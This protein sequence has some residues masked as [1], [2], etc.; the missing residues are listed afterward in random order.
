MTRYSQHTATIIFPGDIEVNP[1]SVDVTIDETRAPAYQATVILPTNLVP[2]G[3]DPRNPTFLG[4]RLRQDFQNLIYVYEVTSDFGGD[5]SDI[6]AVFG[7]DVS[8]ITNNY[9]K[10]WNIFDPVDEPSKI[11]DATLMLR[12]ISKNYVN[13]ETTIELS[14]NEAVLI[15]TI[16]LPGTQPVFSR[17]DLRSLIN[18]IL[19]FCF[20][21]TTEL[22]P[23]GANV[24]YSPAYPVTWAPNQTAWDLLN[25]IV[26][27]ANM[28]LYCDEKGKWYL[29]NVG[30]T[31]GDVVLNDLDNITTFTAT[32]D[33][34]D[35]V[36]FDYALIEYKMD[37]LPAVFDWFGATAGTIIS[38]QAYFLRENITRPSTGGA[39]SLVNRALTRGETYQIEALSNYNT[40]PRQNLLVEITGET[41][42]TGIIQSVTWSLPSARMSVDI[43]NLEEV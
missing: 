27:A 28:V 33:R 17:S 19:T 22:Q 10:P 34:N 9:T 23:G 35:V 40:R 30:S 16:G 5:V 21:L 20:V 26:T 13:K 41:D 29:E 15:D 2:A 7:G 14:S 6:T 24:T 18:T 1:I 25:T 37:A 4:L 42:K 31:S 11:F 32:I 43:R 3:L 38:K 36:F 12:T 39:Q 8:A